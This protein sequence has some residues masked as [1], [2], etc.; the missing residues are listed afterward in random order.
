MKTAEPSSWAGLGLTPSSH[1]DCFQHPGAAASVLGRI[2]ENRPLLI[3]DVRGPEAEP[4]A[5]RKIWDLDSSLHCSV[6]GTCLTTAELR[7]LLGKFHSPLPENPSEHLLHTIAVGGAAQHNLLAKQLQKALDR[8][9]APALRHFAEAKTVQALRQRWSEARKTGDI[10]GAYWAVMT[11][12]KTDHTLIREAFGDVHMLSHLVGAANRADVRKLH[13]LEEEKTALEEKLARQQSQLRDGIA[14]RDTKIRELNA[15][16]STMVEQHGRAVAAEPHPDETGVLRGVV[17]D[18]R[19]LLD[20][21]MLRRE[22]AEKRLEN[23]MLTAQK[24]ERARVAS[25]RVLDNL[26]AELDSLEAHLAAS[27][28]NEDPGAG[29][30][31]GGATILYVGGQ[32]HQIARL[33]LL[34]EKAHGDLIH[35]DGGIEERLDLLPGL[36]SRAAVAFFPIDCVSHPAVSQLKRLCQQAGKPYVPLRSAGVASMLRALREASLERPAASSAA[37]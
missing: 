12:P 13:Q 6:I 30:D 2:R 5:R 35:H 24:A 36:V 34:I 22:R 21:E 37:E 9:H 33:R 16:L 28:A 3:R 19:K 26:R 1:P 15:A 29:L 11:H 10:P 23:L 4:T 31:L 14:S 8:R 20:R 27:E 7:L 18:L 32:P 25:D 17:T